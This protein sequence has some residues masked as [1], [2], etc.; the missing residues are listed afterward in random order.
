MNGSPDDD[1]TLAQAL[2]SERTAGAEPIPGYRLIAP[3]GRGGFG[4]VWKCEAPGGVLKAI[5]FVDGN[6]NS[7]D[8]GANAAS[9]EL[10][11]FQRI[12]AIRH[13]F[14]LSIDRVEI[15]GGELMIVTE[16]ADQ[17]LHDLLTQ[18]R[19]EGKPGI[20]RDELLPLMREAAEALDV[21]A[22]RHE[23]QHLDIKPQNLF[24]VS[25]HVKV[26]DFGL[27]FRLDGLQSTRTER[28]GGVTPTHAS[29]ELLQGRVSQHCDQYSLAIVYQELLTGSLPFRSQNA[30]QLLMQHLTAAPDLSPLPAEERPVVGRALA[31]DPAQRYRSCLE[32][33]SALAGAYP[34]APVREAAGDPAA[35]RPVTPPPENVAGDTRLLL[36]RKRPESGTPM[37]QPRSPGLRTPEARLGQTAADTPTGDTPVRPGAHEG[38]GRGP[39]PAARDSLPACEMVG[40]LGED[41][42]GETWRVRPPHGREVLARFLPEIPG[43]D[44]EAV[45][46]L[47]RRLEHLDHPGLLAMKAYRSGLGRPVMVTKPFGP[48]LRER[49]DECRSQGLTGIPRAELLGRLTRVAELVD[50]LH[51]RYGQP[52][53]GLNP[54]ALRVRGDEVRVGNFGLL[55]LLHEATEQT[56]APLNPG[57]A[58]PELLEGEIDRASDQYSLAVTFAEMLSG[59]RPAGAP[60]DLGMLPEADREVIGRAL[61]PDPADRFDSCATMI[62]ALQGDP[63][64]RAVIGHHFRSLPVI[65]P[66]AILSGERARLGGTV[67]SLGQYVA[68]LTGPDV[69]EVENHAGY[70]SMERGDGAVEYRFPIKWV[71]NLMRA[72]LEGFRNHWDLDTAVDEDER[73]VFRL[74]L[75]QGMWGR[76]T[77]RQA[78]IEVLLEICGPGKANAPLCEAAIRIH[79]FGKADPQVTQKAAELGPLM[80][81]S[82][83]EFLQPRPEG[84]RQVRHTWTHPVHLYPLL[85]DLSP[86]QEARGM[87]RNVSADGISFVVVDD[88][89]TDLAYLYVDT[90]PYRAYAVLVQ[91]LWRQPMERG[92]LVGGKFRASGR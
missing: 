89:P 14:I 1:L 78:G 59:V 29:P 12:K 46:Q 2:S 66:R 36:P 50:A 61:L 39:Q 90:G 91:V 60:Q 80:F 31:K 4:E 77:G 45:Y 26:A 21:M 20:P 86:G 17:N 32:F 52:H 11:A 47:L 92:W 87:G 63:A 37:A 76:W 74:P 27:V 58:A 22:F 33:V 84:R 43:I 30:R 73:F 51:R 35:F 23:L 38:Q 69:R 10:E 24:L 44:D 64:G 5:K 34:G 25:N 82:L 85:A 55:N 70:A 8:A 3:L 54:E 15:T 65:I 62:K 88:L 72:K 81:D 71:P 53:L 9:Q 49:F 18:Y 57:Y 83:R 13:P 67:P 42:L 68:A 19:A 75:A 79:P 7:L 28:R 56:V 48:S 16:L 6:L 40:F 41:S